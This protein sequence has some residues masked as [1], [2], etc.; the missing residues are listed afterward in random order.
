[1]LQQLPAAATAALAAGQTLRIT[2]ATCYTHRLCLE[3]PQPSPAGNTLKHLL[4]ELARR[5]VDVFAEAT[6]PAAESLV[7]GVA[8]RHGA[9]RV[10]T[11]ETLYLHWLLR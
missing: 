1:M 7:Q 5:P 2:Y 4:R 8:R 11:D 9:W 3:P 10:W 6:V